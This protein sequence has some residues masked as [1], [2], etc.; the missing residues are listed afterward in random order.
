MLRLQHSVLVQYMKHLS[1][2]ALLVE[3]FTIKYWSD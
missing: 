3:F 2:K 1:N